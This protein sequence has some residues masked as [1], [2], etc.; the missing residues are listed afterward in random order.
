[1]QTNLFLIIKNFKII[2]KTTLKYKVFKVHFENL[3]FFI[4]FQSIKD[5]KTFAREMKPLKTVKDFYQRIII[6]NDYD[7]NESYD[8]IKHI[9]ILDFLLR[10]K[11]I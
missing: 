7:M 10:K 5:E 3:L 9:N 6:T 1:M 8:G 11:D 2:L 4:S